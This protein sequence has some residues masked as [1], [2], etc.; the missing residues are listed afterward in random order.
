VIS[1]DRACHCRVQLPLPLPA[2]PRESAAQGTGF[3]RDPSFLLASRALLTIPLAL[4][5]CDSAWANTCKD[6]LEGV[7]PF[8][9]GTAGTL[10]QRGRSFLSLICI[11]RC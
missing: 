11:A 7:H 10:S 5:W 6:P 4:P 1:S 9:E 8:P 3:D 2:V